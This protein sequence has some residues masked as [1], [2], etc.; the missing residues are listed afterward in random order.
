[1]NFAPRAHFLLLAEASAD[2]ESGGS[3]RFS[4]DRVGGGHC[5]SA[6]D[7]E[8]SECVERLEL[9]AVIR[10]LEALGEP[11]RV[12]LVTKSRYVSRGLKFGLAEW[13]A[14]DWQWERFG[15]MVAIRDGD[16]WRRLDRA[17]AFHQVECRLWRFASAGADVAAS[18]GHGG[19]AGSRL[20][21]AA[22]SRLRQARDAAAHWGQALQPAGLAA[23]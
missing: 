1:M 13:R 19:S 23:G 20:A 17:L 21:E 8:E 2:L 22:R 14:N 10:G 15:Q 5:L 7:A 16:L 12:T 4:L 18:A 9:L 3:W 11:A 6:A